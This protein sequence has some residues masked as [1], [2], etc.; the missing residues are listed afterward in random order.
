M[1][2]IGAQVV[3]VTVR[4]RDDHGIYRATMASGGKSPLI[5]GELVG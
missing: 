3:F 2:A 5:F 1:F 4:Q